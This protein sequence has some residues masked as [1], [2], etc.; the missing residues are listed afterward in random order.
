MLCP[1]FV[2]TSLNRHLN[3]G[4]YRFDSPLFGALQTVWLA[5]QGNQDY[6]RYRSLATTA[7]IV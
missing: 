1:V 3:F 5:Y 6:F 2:A 4:S 7:V